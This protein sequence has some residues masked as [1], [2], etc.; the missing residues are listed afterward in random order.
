MKKNE[1]NETKSELKGA[2]L[3][4]DLLEEFI[5]NKI[6]LTSSESM[7][8]KQFNSGSSNLT[9]LV[10]VGD[11]KAVLR[12]AP[13]GHINTKAND[14][15]REFRVLKAINPV[16]PLAPKPYL[17]EDDIRILGAPFYMMEMVD[18]VLLE[19]ALPDEND[20]NKELYREVSSSM[21]KAIADIHQI[22]YEDTDLV[23]FTKPEG[24]LKRQVNGWIGRYLN[25]KT[26]EIPGMDQLI[27]W[28]RVNQPISQNPT[29]IHYDFH[30]RNV[31]FSKDNL[32]QITGVLDWEMSTV[33]DP[34]TDLASAL[35]LWVEKTDPE[36]LKSQIGVKPITSRPGFFTRKEFIETYSKITGRDISN[37]NYYLVFGYFKH[38]VIMQ[39]IYYRK[40]KSQIKDDRFT[41]FDLLIR[42]LTDWALQNTLQKW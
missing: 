22:D 2:E 18:G 33:G 6:P 41:N 24:F 31:L 30:L 21:V 38:I 9:Y 8:I 19:S 27:N 10:N 14:I 37:M 42:N 11:W 25:V 23:N 39:Q 16:Y 29:F 4:I 40:K 34:L 7:I 3:N 13:I 12:R 15:H 5:R 26:D 1:T 32:S 17:L 28:I 35:V 20:R 36:Y